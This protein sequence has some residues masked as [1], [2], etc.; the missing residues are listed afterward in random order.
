[1]HRLDPINAKKPAKVF[2]S[3]VAYAKDLGASTLAGFFKV[4]VK[5]PRAG[6]SGGKPTCGDCPRTDSLTMGDFRQLEQRPFKNHGDNRQAL[7]LWTTSRMLTIVR[8]VPSAVG[9]SI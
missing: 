8:V 2:D 3:K 5:V 7:T 9:S 6:V 1:M 4:P